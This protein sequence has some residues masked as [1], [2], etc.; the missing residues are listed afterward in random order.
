MWQPAARLP[1]TNKIDNAISRGCHRCRSV[2]CFVNF[3][4]RW[5]P[6][7]NLIQFQ[8]GETIFCRSRSGTERDLTI[9]QNGLC[10]FVC[11][12]YDY[13]LSTKKCCSVI[14][15]N[16][17]TQLVYLKLERA[18]NCLASRNLSTQPLLR[19]C[20]QAAV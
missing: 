1:A 16:I 9:C 4:V 3:C 15:Y 18:A 10:G 2:V 20:L 17:F 8:P 7:A 11:G 14:G 5:V 13:W 12:L 19:C 6:L